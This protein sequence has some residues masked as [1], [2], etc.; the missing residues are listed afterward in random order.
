[1]NE[2]DDAFDLITLVMVL[3]VFTPIMV[4]CAIPFFKGD[5]GGFDVQIEKTALN[6]ESEIVPVAPE[7][8]VADLLMMMV[9]ADAYTPQPRQLRL[10]FSGK[11]MSVALDENFL[12]DKGSALQTAKSLL[13]ANLNACSRLQLFVGPSGM[14]FWNADLKP[15]PASPEEDQKCDYLAG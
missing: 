10:D 2:T 8:T 1:M 9:V 14:R 5:V 13:P 3:A 15:K 12:S 4:Y 11:Q 7:R 6:T